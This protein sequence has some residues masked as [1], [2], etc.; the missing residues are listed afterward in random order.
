MVAGGEG[1]LPLLLAT[2]IGLAAFL[3]MF[4]NSAKHSLENRGVVKSAKLASLVYARTNANW[5]S[6]WRERLLF[7]RLPATRDAYVL[8]MTGFDTFSRR[9]S[10][11]RKVLETAYEIRDMLLNPMGEGA[12]LRA[13]SLYGALD[14]AMLQTELQE[15]IDALRAMRKLGKKITL[16]FY[17][18]QPFWKLVILGEY[19][20]VQ[21]CHSGCEI[22]DLPEYV[23]ALHS[24]NPKRGLFVPFYMLFLEK[25]N[26]TVHPEYD[27][28]TREL[29]YRNAEGSELRRERFP[30]LPH[31]EWNAVAE[32][33]LEEIVPTI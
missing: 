7:K 24:G 8:T 33:A 9:D 12:R 13:D 14:T 28:D 10:H 26:E 17:D 20:W 23:F 27:F 29:V 11:F 18:D 19:A 1:R 2:E 15:S 21:Y 4:F 5:L 31:V 3:V 30:A 6:R 22:T 25:W 16:K 32:S